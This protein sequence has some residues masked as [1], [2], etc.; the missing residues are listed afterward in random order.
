METAIAYLHFVAVFLVAA[1]LVT[2]FFLCTRD[3]QPAQVKALV[4]VDLYYLIAAVAVLITGALRVFVGKGAGFYLNNPVFY[5]KLAL[6][7]SVG[8]VSIL[9][10]LQ[11][12]RW[13]R[14]LGSIH[15]A[16]PRER[17]IGSARRYIALELLL[18]AFIPLM[19]VLMARGIG[20]RH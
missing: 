7:L 9:P 17:D 11:F 3:L 1:F 6:F 18:F 2:E 10:T 8:L 19:A 16:A 5:I 15:P 13:N 20:P 4:R 12:M 14:A